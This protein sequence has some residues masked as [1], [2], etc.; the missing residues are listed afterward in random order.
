MH[1]YINIY[2]MC[3]KYI[4]ALIPHTAL[5]S[6]SKLPQGEFLHRDSPTAA[7]I[8]KGPCRTE[9]CLTI[10]CILNNDNINYI[11]FYLV[12][13]WKC[14]V[15][16]TTHIYTHIYTYIHIR[17]VTV[18]KIHSSVRYDTVV[19]RFGMF[20]IRGGG[21]WLRRNVGNISVLNHEGEPM[22]IPQARVCTRV[23]TRANFAQD[24]CRWTS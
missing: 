16:S 22:D 10:Y 13:Q 8:T 21:N 1:I 14:H 17:G 20:S 7:F 5:L 15:T 9:K 12:G 11:H 19:S 4:C 23:Y 24:L 18:H 6:H 2:S 3:I